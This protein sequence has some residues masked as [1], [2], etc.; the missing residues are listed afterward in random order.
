MTFEKHN[1][2]TI[3]LFTTI[4][5]FFYNEFD[6]FLYDLIVIRVR[7]I[8]VLFPFSGGRGLLCRGA[9]TREWMIMF[10]YLLK[11]AQV[12]SISCSLFF[13]I[14]MLGY[15]MGRAR[16]YGLMFINQWLI[17]DL[18]QYIWLVLSN[19]INR[20]ICLSHWFRS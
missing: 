18:G 7:R 9:S 16:N 6:I 1:Q 10:A 17:C 12:H 13:I 11:Y 20:D 2:I 15:M 8:I 5:D 19:W 3:S 14:N 4:W